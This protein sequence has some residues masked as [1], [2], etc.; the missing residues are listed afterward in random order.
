MDRCRYML[1]INSAKLKSR[2]M[3]FRYLTLMVQAEFYTDCC[4]QT[5]N[6]MD[7]NWTLF[8]YT[9]I[10]LILPLELQLSTYLIMKLRTYLFAYLIK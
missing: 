1:M 3:L 7:M 10:L 4:K 9:F 5:E 8:N 2:Y 6:W